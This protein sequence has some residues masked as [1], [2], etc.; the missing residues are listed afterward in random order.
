MHRKP[1]PLQERGSK[2]SDQSS[3][4]QGERRH[5]TEMAKEKILYTPF[6]CLQNK[7]SSEEQRE[8]KRSHFYVV[9]LF[10][11]FFI[12]SVCPL[13]KCICQRL[14]VFFFFHPSPPTELP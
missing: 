13:E 8:E 5:H 2:Q 9:I 6:R 1:Y 14:T 10:L 11:K 12:V 3:F 7:C 4:H